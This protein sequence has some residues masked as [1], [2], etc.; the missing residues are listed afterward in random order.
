[1]DAGKDYGIRSV[2]YYALR[3]LRIE[4]FIPFW[5]E[6]LDSHTTPFEVGRGFK[7]KMQVRS[8]P[9]S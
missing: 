1:M 4:K 7:V 5:A 6:E 8:L 9:Q 3:F 2:G